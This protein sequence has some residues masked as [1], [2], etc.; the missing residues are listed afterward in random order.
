MTEK[1]WLNAKEMRALREWW[2]SRK[3]RDKYAR[4]ERLFA[5]ACARLWWDHLTDERSRRA[6][7]AAEKFADGLIAKTTLAR[8]RAPATAA[9]HARKG[10]TPKRGYSLE[11]SVQIIMNLGRDDVF[12]ATT[13][14]LLDAAPDLKLCTQKESEAAQ[15]ALLRDI[16]GNPFRKVGFSK[17]WRTDTAVALA[18]QMYD[19]RE[20]S[21]MPIL[22]DAL[23]DAGCNNDDV[24]NHCRE[25]NARHVRGCWVVDLVLG[26]E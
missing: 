23:Q 24:L 19:S 9:A 22:A 10:R 18:K 12:V 11:S 8:T 6:V 17:E 26:K 15:V 4:K 2:R 13:F 20:F 5:C 25:A 14:R 16:M 21:A 7:E 3:G 1:E